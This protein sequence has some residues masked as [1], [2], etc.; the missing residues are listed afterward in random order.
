MT[1]NVQTIHFI[2]FR[3]KGKD[4]VLDLKYIKEIIRMASLSRIDELPAFVR[5]VINLRGESLPVVD[6]V[7]RAGGEPTAITLRSRIMVMR[8]G[9]VSF[10]LLVDDVI[11]T[12]AVDRSQIS[13]NVQS[14]VVINPKY[15]AGTFYE[16][17]HLLIWVDAL[18]LFTASEFKKL[19]EGSH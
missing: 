3:S 18:K 16:G 1:G 14:D 11:E 7:D 5:G 8:M 6:F 15:I 12:L 19:E 17:D 4:Y 13:G 2:H 9:E 10:G